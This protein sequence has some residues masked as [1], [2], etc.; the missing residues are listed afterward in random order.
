MEKKLIFEILRKQPFDDLS[1]KLADLFEKADA[2]SASCAVAS[3]SAAL[4][5]R[6]ADLADSAVPAEKERI[7]YIRRNTEIIRD[8]MDHL[9][10][11]DVRCRGPIRKAFEDGDPAKITACC[12]SACAIAVETIDMMRT[13]LGFCDELRAFYYEGVP[14][15]LFEAAS[16][17]G[18]AVESASIYIDSV[19]KLSDDETYAFIT[20]RE[21]RIYL[22]DCGKLKEKIWSAY[23]SMSPYCIRGRK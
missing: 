16:L 20:N 6:A 1:A 22:E 13:L 4:L 17:A 18:A 11:E 15:Y 9:I 21:I 3:M 12:Q 10:D 19:T 2:G 7:E 14:H 23:D 5:K 8:Y